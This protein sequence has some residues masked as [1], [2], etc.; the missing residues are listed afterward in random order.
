MF[1]W[2]ISAALAVSGGIFIVVQ[3]GINVQARG[4]LNSAVW[5]GVISFAVGLATMTLV[6]LASR[7]PLPVAAVASRVPWWVWSGGFFG[8]LY[9]GLAIFLVPQLGANTFVVLL[10]AGQMVTSIVIDHYGFFGLEQRPIDVTRLLGVAFLVAGVV[11]VK[12]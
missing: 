6:A 9:I 10:V 4:V 7:D 3:Q 5:A 2:L 8:A 1:N 11:L 12:R